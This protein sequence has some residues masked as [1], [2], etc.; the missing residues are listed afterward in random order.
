M[1]LMLWSMDHSLKTD[2]SQHS[3][4][5]DGESREEQGRAHDLSKSPFKKTKARILGVSPKCIF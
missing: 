5:I 3:C 2:L 1:M 4:F